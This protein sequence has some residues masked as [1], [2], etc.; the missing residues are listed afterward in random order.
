MRGAVLRSRQLLVLSVF[1]LLGVS[2][3]PLCAA[4]WPQWRG[5]ERTGVA[6]DGVPLA[7]AW[8]KTGPKLVWQ[9]DN[10]PGGRST[11]FGSPVIANGRVYLYRNWPATDAPPGNRDSLICLDAGTGA[12]IWQKI[13]P[14]AKVNEADQGGT[15]CVTGGKLYVV[16]TRCLLCLDAGTGDLVWKT[17]IPN[18]DIHGYCDLASSP[19]VVDGVVVVVAAGFRGFDARTGELRWVNDEQPRTWGDYTSMAPWIKDGKT[20]VVGERYDYRCF[21]PLTGTLIWKVGGVRCGGGSWWGNSTPVIIGDLMISNPVNGGLECDQLTMTGP[22]QLW[23]VPH[24]DVSTAPLVYQGYVY[25]IGGGDY[26]HQTTMKCIELQTGDVCWEIKTPGQGCS[27]PIAVDGNILGYMNF[28]KVLV[29]MKATP[30]AC[31]QLAYLP[32]QGDGYS[33]PAFADGKIVMRTRTGLICYDL[34]A[35]AN[36]GK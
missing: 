15:P 22:K 26:G 17:Q 7:N 30:D 16:G 14:V 9:V 2:L 5:P 13:F 28:G 32:M 1:C 36:P 8:P 19:L 10:L 24:H 12:L 11:G 29:M 21:D 34:T 6:P 25:T 3:K 31:T 33:S 35:A 18:T 23:N 27:S 4:D 20:Y